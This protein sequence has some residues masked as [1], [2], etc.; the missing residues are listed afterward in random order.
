MAPRD[1]HLLHARVALRQTAGLAL[2]GVAMFAAEVVIHV[3]EFV[4]RAT[5]L[6][7]GLGRAAHS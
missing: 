1:S 3:E 7:P 6:V 5:R 4:D 2:M